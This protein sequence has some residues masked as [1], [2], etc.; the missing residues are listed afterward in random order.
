MMVRYRKLTHGTVTRTTLS[1]RTAETWHGACNEIAN[2]INS[3]IGFNMVNRDGRFDLQVPDFVISALG[4][5]ILL[6]PMLELLATV[7][8]QPK[9]AMRTHNIIFVP[10]GSGAQRWHFDDCLRMQKAHR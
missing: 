1:G 4:M 9:P 7:M 6:A 5:D 10:V 8:G 2:R 3:G